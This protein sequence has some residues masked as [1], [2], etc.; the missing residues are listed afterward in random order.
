[1]LKFEKE[2]ISKQ[3]PPRENVFINSSFEDN[4]K[5][6]ARNRLS[7]EFE[8]LIKDVNLQLNCF[9]KGL[10]KEMK[11]DLKYVTSLEDDFDETC[12]ILDIQQ[13]F[14]KTQFESVRSESQSHVYE[15]QMFEQNSSLKNENRYLKKTITE[16][17]KQAV[18]VK[19]EM[20]KRCAQYEKDFS[21]LEAHCISLKPNSLKK[22]STSMQNGQ[23]L[24][25]KSGEAKFKFDT[26][27]LE[28]INIKLEYSVAS[29]LKENEHLKTI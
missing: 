17:S 11:D 18:D 3:N 24:T 29:L 28:T 23:V 12:L 7:K 9:E 15:N 6:I 1:M 20:T 16:L 14:F 4:V 25:N 2:T 21:K 5:R 8:P 13:E 19:E 26:E 10:V 27:Y 22:S